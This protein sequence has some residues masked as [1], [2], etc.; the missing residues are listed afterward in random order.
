M[1]SIRYGIIKRDCTITIININFCLIEDAI[2]INNVTNLN[3]NAYISS[4]AIKYSL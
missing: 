3:Q 2:A 4:T 1:V